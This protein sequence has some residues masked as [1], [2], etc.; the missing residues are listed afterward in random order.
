VLTAS[1]SSSSRKDDDATQAGEAHSSP[2]SN[3]GG[4]GSHI[5]SSRQPQ[6]GGTSEHHPIYDQFASN[7]PSRTTGQSAYS[8]TMSQNLPDSA[9][10]FGPSATQST[11]SSTLRPD[12]GHGRPGYGGNDIST[13]SIK[14]GVLGFPQGGG[15]A[16]MSHTPDLDA[17]QAQGATGLP[18]RTA[19]RFV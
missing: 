3:L 9:K 7:S 14:S 10:G 1:R 4:E 6:S 11:Q 8:P 16:A 17:T 13:A 18:D 15:H 2:T 5:G 19:T 12:T